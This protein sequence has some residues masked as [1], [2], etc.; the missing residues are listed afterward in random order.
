MGSCRRDA[1]TT[2]M[3]SILVLLLCSLVTSE[4]IAN[5]CTREDAKKAEYGASTLST[6]KQVFRSYRR[7]S[8]CDDG[9]ISEGYSSSVAAL[10]ANRWDSLEDLMRL[11]KADGSFE[12]FVLRHVDDTMSRDQDVII[13]KNLRQRCPEDAA[14]FCLALAK[15]FA[16]LDSEP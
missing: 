6:W 4:A 12:T 16:E 9:A 15:R 13:R 14:H 1:R 7:Y 5:Q 2:T 10:L 3:L 11:I 8:G